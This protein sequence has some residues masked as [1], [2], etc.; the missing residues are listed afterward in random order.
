M[1][2]CMRAFFIMLLCGF[3]SCICLPLA[4]A[5]LSLAAVVIAFGRGKRWLEHRTRQAWA[6]EDAPLGFFAEEQL[7]KFYAPLACKPEH[8]LL[9]ALWLGDGLHDP[10]QIT[11][12][13][14]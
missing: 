12:C 11:V 1:H 7:L 9:A 3:Q 6:S 8:L 14:S 10:L 4:Q 5:R 2:S 13:L